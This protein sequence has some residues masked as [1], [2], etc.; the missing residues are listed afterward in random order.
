[1]RVTTLG[2]QLRA[3]L[4]PA[5]PSVWALASVFQA[6]GYLTTAM[7]MGQWNLGFFTAAFVGWFTLALCLRGQIGTFIFHIF[8]TA[9]FLGLTS[10]PLVWP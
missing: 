1:M 7:Q 8:L 4:A 6:L 5:L 3:R 10:P 2:A 9:T